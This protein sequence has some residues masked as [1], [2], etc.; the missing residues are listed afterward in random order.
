M[1][2]DVGKIVPVDW[3]NADQNLQFVLKKK[4]AVSVKHGKFFYSIIWWTEG[5]NLRSNSWIMDLQ[6]QHNFLVSECKRSSEN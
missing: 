1:T 6:T 4:N 5:Y 3:L 2:N